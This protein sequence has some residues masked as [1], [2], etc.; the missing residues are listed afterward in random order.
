[1]TKVIRILKHC[2]KVL[3]KCDTKERFK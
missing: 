2:Q 1:M 3:T